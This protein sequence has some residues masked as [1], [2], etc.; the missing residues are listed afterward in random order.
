VFTETAEISG[1]L[2]LAQKIQT[3]IVFAGE[4]STLIENICGRSFECSYHETVCVSND[5]DYTF[6][7][8]IGKH[9]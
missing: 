8:S 1:F 6:E 9:Y 4:N 2:K 7:V 5:F 3:R